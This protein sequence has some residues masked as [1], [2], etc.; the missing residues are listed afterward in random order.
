[1]DVP[2][3][4]FFSI[5]RFVWRHINRMTVTSIRVCCHFRKGGVPSSLVEINNIFQSSVKL[6]DSSLSLSILLVMARPGKMF[7]IPIVL[8]VCFQIL[9]VNRWS[10]S[11]TIEVGL[12]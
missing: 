7:L 3:G 12:P 1:M 11:L 4:I 6:P 9:E 5:H 2:E 10:A 8:R